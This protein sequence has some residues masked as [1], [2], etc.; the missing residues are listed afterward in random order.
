MSPHCTQEA[1]SPDGASFTTFVGLDVSTARLDSFAAGG[2]PRDDANTPQVHASF[3]AWLRGS[4]AP[5]L[6][7]LGHRRL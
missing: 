7:L 6:R 1:T 5:P 3:V 2:T 4:P